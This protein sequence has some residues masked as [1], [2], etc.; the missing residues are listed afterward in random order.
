MSNF[1]RTYHTKFIFSLAS[2]L[3]DLEGEVQSVQVQLVSQG[4]TVDEESIVALWVGYQLERHLYLN[5]EMDGQRASLLRFSHLIDPRFLHHN[6]LAR[7]L[8]L[9]Q[10]R[11]VLTYGEKVPYTDRICRVEVRLPDLHLYFL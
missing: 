3:P 2:I 9:D 5:M 8:L 4:V 7:V 10:V 1:R 11:P 6:V